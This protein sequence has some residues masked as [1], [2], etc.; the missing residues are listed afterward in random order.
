MRQYMSLILCNISNI[1]TK[2]SNHIPLKYQNTALS[3]SNNINNKKKKINI[4]SLRIL[5]KK[6]ND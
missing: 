3:K 6:V 4:K 1:T 2:T 5:L